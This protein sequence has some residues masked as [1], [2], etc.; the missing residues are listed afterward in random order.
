MS[1]EI[2]VEGIIETELIVPQKKTKTTRVLK[3]P[4]EPKE[5]KVP[6]PKKVKEIP[7]SSYF[8]ENEFAEFYGADPEL[9]SWKNWVNCCNII[10]GTDLFKKL[11]KNEFF[12]W[13][14][15]ENTAHIY[16]VWAKEPEPILNFDGVQVDLK[17]GIYDENL[18]MVLPPKFFFPT[19]RRY[20]LSQPGLD[21][22]LNNVD[23]KPFQ[24][25]DFVTK[26]PPRP[27]QQECVDLAE[28]E[29][30][31]KKY[32][33]GIIQAP[34]GWGKT[35]TSI[36]IG[37]LTNTQI[38]IVV[39]NKLLAEQWTDAVTTFTDL[40]A[41]DIGFLK[42]SNIKALTKKGQMK[43]PV[44]IALVQ[45]LD[46]QLNRVPFEELREFYRHIGAVFYDETHT[47]GAADG[48]AK[49]SGIFTTF[50]VIG[51]SATPYKKGTN[52]FQ[53]YTGIGQIKYIST[54]QNLIPTC[55]MHMLPVRISQKE[56]ESI[57]KVYEQ[58]NWALFLN[59]LENLLFK[60][61]YYFTFLSEWLLYRYKQ[62]YSSVVLFKTNQML[63]KL[64]RYVNDKSKELNLEVIPK[65]VIL[66][67]ETA[68]TQKQLINSSD[69]V[70]SNFRMF[71]AGADYPHLSNVF[72][73][74]MVLGKV[75]IIQTLGRVTRK[76][77]DKI[78]DV[79]AHFFIPDFIYPLFSSNEPHLTIIRAVKTQY[80]ES[81]FKWD[82]G[83]NEY[84]EKKKAAAENLVA[85]D[86]T[87]FQTQQHRGHIPETGKGPMQGSFIVNDT[88]T[89]DNR[90]TMYQQ[91]QQYNQY[92]Q[93][94]QYQAN[95]TYQQPNG[96]PV[97]P[98]VPQPVQPVQS[99][100]FQNMIQA[101]PP[102]PQAPQVHQ[103]PPIS[104]DQD[105]NIPPLMMVQSENIQI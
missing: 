6:K 31:N 9:I 88:T 68:K 36:R 48:Y 94:Q 38:L 50:N 67:S 66:T 18:T 55:N 20:L 73:A 63:E 30:K 103:A 61:H 12:E 74:S 3:E 34:P 93:Y 32:F 77:S 58:G 72:F 42:G 2:N 81:Q 17:P 56:R 11:Y 28:D 80:P 13:G 92:Q 40:T 16:P 85:E 60:D 33:K 105:P 41:D 64:Q 49:T 57:F 79:Q 96:F 78:Q 99:Y 53:L 43:K 7:E 24:K 25:Y 15:L 97:P 87:K 76:F 90:L 35:Y 14:A 86:Y 37:S 70:F 82:K 75:P 52:L 59:I 54:H 100:P 83:F 4:K 10:R 39:P 84:F 47:S 23:V 71:S 19:Y 5:P 51:L 8:R 89:G 29:L 27:E 102:V 44:L 104:P 22:I 101:M 46:S 26:A 62:G 21:H 98:P 91:Q 1:V 65:S 45:S 95:Q 69:I